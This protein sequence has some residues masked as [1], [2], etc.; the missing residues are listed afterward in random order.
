MLR[1]L[2]FS[3][4]ESEGLTFSLPS[5]DP[6]SGRGVGFGYLEVCVGIVSSRYLRRAVRRGQ[7]V[8]LRRRLHR[9]P[10]TP[11]SPC[12]STSLGL[13]KDRIHPVREVLK[14]GHV[15]DALTRFAI[16]LSTHDAQSFRDGFAECRDIPTFDIDQSVAADFP[17][18]R[19]VECDAR[20]AAIQRLDRRESE[21]LKE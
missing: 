11:G 18:N 6:K 8:R 21:S 1:R 9:E 17:Q 10:H 13:F 14:P 15:E 5:N 16:F 7:L 2:L 20:N 4:I 12:A 19:Q 3:M